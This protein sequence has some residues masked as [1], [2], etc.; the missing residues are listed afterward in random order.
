MLV[1]LILQTAISSFIVSTFA[2]YIQELLRSALGVVVYLLIAELTSEASMV[3]V[4]A[5]V[6]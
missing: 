6:L 5:A 4:C 3:R 2:A 1:T